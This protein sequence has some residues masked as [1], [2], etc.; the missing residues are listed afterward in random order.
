MSERPTAGQSEQQRRSS[1]ER[2][3]NIHAD[4]RIK[5]SQQQR[6]DKHD[7]GQDQGYGYI[8]QT[9]DCSDFYEV[10]GLSKSKAE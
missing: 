1:A 3:R 9:F 5:R 7:P 10:P 2:V 8:C 4:I 6:P